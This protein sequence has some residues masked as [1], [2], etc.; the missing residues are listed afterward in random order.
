MKEEK[1]M[2]ERDGLPTIEKGIKNPLKFK[3]LKNCIREGLWKI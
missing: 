3:K 2:E 1:K